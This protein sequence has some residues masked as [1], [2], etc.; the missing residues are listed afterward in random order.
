MTGEVYFF[1]KRFFGGFNKKDVVGYIAKLAQERNELAAAKDKA[2]NDAKSLAREIAALRLKIE[3]SERLVLKDL[4]RKSSVFETAENTFKEF[5][6][7]FKGL[8][9]SIETSSTGISAELENAFNTVA[10]LSSVLERAGAR[11]EELRAAFDAE[12]GEGSA[13]KTDTAGEKVL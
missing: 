11:I 1:R 2:D 10:K 9:E 3:E 13:A 5:D 7:A 6:T 8:R 4:E 12:K